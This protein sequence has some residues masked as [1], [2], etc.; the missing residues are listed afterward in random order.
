MVQVVINPENN[1][2]VHQTA[3]D[4]R[5]EWVLAIKG[6]VNL[7]PK[8]TV[9]S[10]IPTGE[11]EV[12]VEHLEVLNT[13]KTPPFNIE[14]ESVN[15][16]ELIRL[17]YR[18]M[19]LRR[20]TLKQNLVK[21]HVLVK[22]I[23]DFLD[24][25]GFIEVETP[26]LTKSTPEGA[27]DYLVPSRIHPGSF[28]ALP[29]SPQQMKQLLVM[30]GIEKYFQIAKCFR[31][32]DLRA[33][34][35]PEFTQL[36]LE[37]GFVNENDVLKIMEELFTG[38]TETVSPEKKL[39]KPF[40]RFTYNEVIERFGTDKP[41]L[42]FDIELGN[43]SEIAKRSDFQIFS[44]I[45]N[46]GGVVKG[47]VAPGCSGYT[48][49]EIEEL[50]NFAQERG[51]SG[52]VT[53]A[54]DG[55]PTTPI[56]TLSENEFRS[57]VARYLK[58]GE[59]INI[60]SKLGAKRGDLILIIA[61][62]N[63]VVNTALSQC[64]HEIGRRLCLAD[65]DLL[66]FAFIVDFP[67]LEW[68]PEDNRW[69]STHNPFSSPKSTDL[70]L[71]DTNPELVRANQ[72]DLV[73]NGLEIG[74]GSIRNHNRGIQ[75]KIFRLLGHS[76]TQMQNQFGQILDALEYGAP[77][78]GGFAAGIDRMVMLVTNQDNIREVIAFPKTQNG[79]DPLFGAPSEVDE[80]QLNE[81]HIRKLNT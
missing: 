47:F 23:R 2:E 66:S 50:I 70:H 79:V 54:L 6:K 57:P 18:Y 35:Q 5:N 25:D 10:N 48:R 52:L 4:I 7:R 60:S 53:I 73:C 36:D 71:L 37:M 65:P 75:E 44:N 21:R 1:P 56:E 62:E 26:I 12:M 69:D 42:R 67:L 74:G 63:K 39:V 46:S 58:T 61:G 22:Y 38:L 28:Y 41:D 40:P 11:I 81:V 49:S 78:H 17:K 14:D 34:R 8:G 31:D 9:N 27:R 19:D 24:R 80:S 43:L 68:R 15:T 32:E 33:D 59:V 55:D 45:A 72:Y 77:P 20:N 3:Q 29:Q 51:A 13:S 30:G 16:E 64:R 76:Q